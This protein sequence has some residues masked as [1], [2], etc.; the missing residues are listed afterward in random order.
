MINDYGFHLQKVLREMCKWV[1][2]DPKEI[3]FKKEHWFMEHEWTIGQQNDFVHWL[4]DYLYKND[5][6][7]KELLEHP[8]KNKKRC[9]KSAEWFVFNYGWKST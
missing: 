5:G 8:L 7:R 1:G 3:D 4:T 2:A 9:R 6:A